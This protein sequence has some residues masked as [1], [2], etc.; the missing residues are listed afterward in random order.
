MTRLKPHKNASK[1][2]KRRWRAARLSWITGVKKQSSLAALSHL[3]Q[4]GSAGSA[5]RSRD[6]ARGA[7]RG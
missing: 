2:A 3:G 5:A 7:V 4:E 1:G 6:G